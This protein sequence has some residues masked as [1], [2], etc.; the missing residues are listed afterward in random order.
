MCSGSWRGGRGRGNKGS[1]SEVRTVIGLSSASPRA[2]SGEGLE[3]RLTAVNMY[4][5]E[6]WSARITVVENDI[7]ES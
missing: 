2:L 4:V 7:P 3:D 1:A 5:M 6:D